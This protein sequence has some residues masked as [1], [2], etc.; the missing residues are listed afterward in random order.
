[1]AAQFFLRCLYISHY[2]LAFL[3]LH[4]VSRNFVCF[5]SSISSRSNS[6]PCPPLQ[7]QLLKYAAPR[8]LGSMVT[9]QQP[10]LR[11]H[12]FET[13]GPFGTYIGEELPH[14]FPPVSHDTGL[15]LVIVRSDPKTFVV[16]N[17]QCRL[18]LYRRLPS[19]ASLGAG[20]QQSFCRMV[21]ICRN[22]F[23]NLLV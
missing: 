6:S 20:V 7:P 18:N 4:Y 22:F 19:Q 15:S 23:G 16:I 10:R 8:N 21:Y 13:F 5:C 17:L 3:P 14:E 1:M 9:G 11:G 12:P 2:F